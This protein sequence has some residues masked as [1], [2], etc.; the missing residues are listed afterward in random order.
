MT[1]CEIRF[2]SAEN[3]DANELTARRALSAQVYPPEEAASWPGRNLQWAPT[4]A[5]FY[6]KD[7]TGNLVSYVGIVIREGNLNGVRV[8]IGGIGG[9]MTHPASRRKGYARAAI[10]DALNYFRMQQDVDFA[11]LVCEPNLVRYYESAGWKEF[12]GQLKVRQHGATVD[13]T[14][15]RAMTLGIRSAAPLEG[16]IDLLGAPW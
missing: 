1:G 3:L 10:Q 11:L 9:V 7:S 14:F 15:N 4:E 8:R 2:L 13:F 16:E 5:G 12:E 6:V